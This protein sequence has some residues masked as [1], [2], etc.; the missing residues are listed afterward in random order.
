LLGN[1][2]SKT[3]LDT[4]KSASNCSLQDFI[5]QLD[6]EDTSDDDDDDNSNDDDNNDE[7]QDRGENDIKY[8]TSGYNS[9]EDGT[10]LDNKVAY[11]SLRYKLE[12]GISK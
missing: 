8:A 4:L 7:S 2:N 10:K 6:A 5:T 9:S 1:R 3:F 11:S 12:M